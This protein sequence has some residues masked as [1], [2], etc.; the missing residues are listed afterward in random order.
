MDCER[1]RVPSDLVQLEK[2]HARTWLIYTLPQFI[3]FLQ[4][5]VWKALQK[6]IQPG[7]EYQLVRKFD[8]TL[9]DGDIFVLLR[10]RNTGG[11]DIDP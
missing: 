2:R 5:D 7:A 8:G 4:P 3:L 11:N 6:R 10:Q 9:G 1:V